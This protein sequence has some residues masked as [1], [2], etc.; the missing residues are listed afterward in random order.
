MML[1][2]L[3]KEPIDN[4]WNKNLKGFFTGNIV[5]NENFNELCKLTLVTPII[6]ITYKSKYSKEYSEFKKTIQIDNDTAYKN[7]LTYIYNDVKEYD[8]NSVLSCLNLYTM[9]YII[10]ILLVIQ[11]DF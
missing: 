1:K 11:V 4:F 9:N 6:E 3:L 2:N 10:M 8:K 7:M 5:N